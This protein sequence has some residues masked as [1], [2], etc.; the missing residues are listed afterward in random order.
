MCSNYFGKYELDLEE[1]KI[2]IA[3]LQDKYKD[4]QRILIEPA[5]MNDARLYSVETRLTE[6]EE[7]RI[8]E[9]EYLRDLLKKL[10]YSLEQ[11]N[12]QQI[13]SKG[14]ATTALNLNSDASTMDAKTTEK[15]PNL[16]TNTGPDAARQS[17]QN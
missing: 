4:W 11:V 10:L 5:T 14:L 7:M 16:L 3:N 17:M 1:V 15:L 6:E 12:M 9:Y 13:D 2:R 8:R